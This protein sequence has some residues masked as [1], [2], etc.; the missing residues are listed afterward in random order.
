MTS[1][2]IVAIHEAGHAVVAVLLSRPLDEVRLGG[3]A[4]GAVVSGKAY[5]VG[6]VPEEEI[7]AW[8][9]IT[10]GGP[11]AE[12]RVSGTCENGL[13][14]E[15]GAA[16]MA[17]ELGAGK[18]DLSAA[19]AEGRAQA[20]KLLGSPEAWTAVEKV[21]AQLLSHQRI[22]G[23]EMERIVRAEVSIPPPV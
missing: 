19:V 12:E 10:F 7:R 2:E 23:T 17:S 16:A 8:I 9:A 4:D 22:D 13:A 20:A 3:E 5:K 6:E 11:I 1:D 15:V 14:H 18:A 21:A